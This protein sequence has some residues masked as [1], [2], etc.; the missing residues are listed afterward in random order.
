MAIDIA[1]IRAAT[2]HAQSISDPAERKA[3]IDGF[4]KGFWADVASFR[5][6]NAPPKEAP[7]DIEK[8]RAATAHAQSISDPA[9]RKVFIDG[10]L[11]DLWA[12]VADY[13]KKVRGAKIDPAKVREATTIAQSI[14]DP[15][16][17]KAFIEAFLAG[18]Y[19]D[20]KQWRKMHPKSSLIRSLTAPVRGVLYGMGKLGHGVAW[21]VKKGIAFGV[22]IVGTA[23]LLPLVAYIPAMRHKLKGKGIKPKNDLPGLA[24]Q[25]YK[26]VVKSSYD[27]DYLSLNP[28]TIVKAIIN[29]LR[30]IKDKQERGD[31]LSPEEEKIAELIDTATDTIIEGGKDQAA[32]ETGAWLRENSTLVIA[33]VV[34]LLYLAFRP[35]SS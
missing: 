10:F 35:K 6:Q 24:T 5:E 9:E 31:D 4:L 28:A 33:G 8:I 23:A 21:M 20:L 18:M 2:A 12:N 3:F 16:E 27:I 1:K 15:V 32:T 13:R 17:R 7:I 26:N 29:Y 11:K 22:K 25:F 14:S 30:G 34:V 19:K